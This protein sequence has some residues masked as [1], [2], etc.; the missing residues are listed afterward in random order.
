[1]FQINRPTTEPSATES[2]HNLRIV[3]SPPLVL[4][5]LLMQMLTGCI[6]LDFL[7]TDWTVHRSTSLSLTTNYTTVY[8]F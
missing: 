1:M 7:F 4:W 8:L 3:G 6:V 2:T 5:M